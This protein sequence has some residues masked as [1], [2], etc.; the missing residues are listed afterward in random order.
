MAI[1]DVTSERGVV[2]GLVVLVEREC[3]T[4]MLAIECLD[5]LHEHVVVGFGAVDRE[6]EVLREP[7]GRPEHELAKARA[8]LEGE[9]IAHTRVDKGM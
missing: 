9:V 2:V 3:D 4:G 8:A 6:I 5:D 1:E 7:A